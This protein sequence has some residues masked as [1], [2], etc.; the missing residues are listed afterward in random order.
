[1]ITTPEPPKFFCD[2]MLGRLA[3]RMRLAGI[4]TAYRN[5]IG[6]RELLEAAAGE[7]RV[8]VTRDRRLA[9]RRAARGM[10]V[11]LDSDLVDA[12]WRQLLT[13]FPQLA[14]I[15]SLTRCAVCNTE[16]E[17]VPRSQVRWLVPIYVYETQPEIRRCRTCGR[18][19]WPGTH[20]ARMRRRWLPIRSGA[21]DGR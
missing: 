18:L 6:D 17:V 15:P 8:V 1:M 4:D 7:N 13:V 10:C 9:D 20:I 21:N 3:R 2:A 14:G 12:Q 16:L 11:L 19:Y 5:Q